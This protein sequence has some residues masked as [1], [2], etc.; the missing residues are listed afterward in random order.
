MSVKYKAGIVQGWIF[1]ANA[2]EM[3]NQAT[4][5]QY[6]D[7]FI[8]PNDWDCT[9]NS[10]FGEWVVENSE[11]GTAINIAESLNKDSMDIMSWIKKFE[12]AGLDGAELTPPKIYLINQIY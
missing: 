9:E 7:D 1:S 12:K 2:K 8:I 5:Y 10:I 6:E 11:P 3:F 4:D